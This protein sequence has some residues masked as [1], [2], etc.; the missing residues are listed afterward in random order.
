MHQG[1]HLYPGLPRPGRWRLSAGTCPPADLLLGRLL[2]ENPEGLRLI[3]LGEHV[4][5][6]NDLGWRDRF[7]SALFTSRQEGY[8]KTTRS[9]VFTPQLVVNGRASALG[10]DA[11]A[12]RA[13]ISSSRGLRSIRVDPQP[14]A[15]DGGVDVHLTAT[16]AQG[17]AGEVYVALVQDRATSR[18]SSGDNAGRTLTH[19]AVARSL[20]RVGTG[21]GAYSGHVHF[22][23][24]QS[25]G[26]DSLVVFVQEPGGGPVHA[27]GTAGLR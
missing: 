2:A 23:A 21:A 7:S 22:S 19:V 12:V 25:S 26:A 27:A 15:S 14:P 1:C 11:A 13:A 4:D 6:W 5:Y 17:V 24:A 20:V 8:A 18:V 3:A 10:S 16:W 9:T